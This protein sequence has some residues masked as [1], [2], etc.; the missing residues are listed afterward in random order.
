[1]ASNRSDRR[2]AIMI[3]KSTSAKEPWSTGSVRF[4][5]SRSAMR[6]D[7]SG[8]GKNTRIC[9]VLK[10]ISNSFPRG[11]SKQRP[12][13]RRLRRI[14]LVADSGPVLLVVYWMLSD[15]KRSDYTTRSQGRQADRGAN[16]PSIL[17]EQSVLTL[18]AKLFSKKKP[19]QESDEGQPYPAG[20]LLPPCKVL[21][22]VFAGHDRRGMGR[23]CHWTGRSARR[24]CHDA[25]AGRPRPARAFRFLTP[26]AIADHRNAPVNALGYLRVMFAVDDID[27][28]LE[29]LRKRG[30]QLVGD[31][32][33]YKDAYRLCY[34][35]G[36]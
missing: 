28:T 23:T 5:F 6:N 2:F 7:G 26:P 29:R 24:D 32:V 3:P 19:S 11:G 20:V 30:A 9:H 8:F 35:R 12:L 1:M 16:L 22:K 33:Q 36:V 10:N 18:Y 13:R 34:I 21:E 4:V 27:E 25:H 15:D 17:Q 14:L 31:V